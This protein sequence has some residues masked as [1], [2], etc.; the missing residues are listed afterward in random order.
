MN[1]P[2]YWFLDDVSV[3]DGG[4]QLVVNGG[5]ETGTVS[6]WV[7]TDPY[8]I[9]PSGSTPT[10]A[11]ALYRHTG[12]YASCSGCNTVPDQLSQ[13]LSVIAGHN[14]VISFWMATRSLGSGISALVTI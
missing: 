3:Y 9:C 11:C 13:S 4:T 12:S 6:P 8:G 14:Y 2:D 1:S 5:F 7:V 10:A